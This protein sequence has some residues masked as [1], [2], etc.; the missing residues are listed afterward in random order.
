MRFPCLVWSS[1]ACASALAAAPAPAIS[2]A[3]ILARI[4]VLA[5]DE[6][7]GRAPGSAGED[8]TIAFLAAEFKRLGLQPGNPDGS[9]LQ[10]VPLVGI[11]TTVRPAFAAGGATLVPLP[12]T[13]FVARSRRTAPSLAVKDAGIIFCGYG[14]V[15]PEYQWDDFKGVD[16]RGK[17]IVVLV[18]DPPVVDPQT[19]R[20]DPRVFGGK[21]MT[22]YGRWDYKYEQA[23]ALGAAACLIVHETGPAAY[24]F[25][26]VGSRSGQEEFDLATPD[27]NAGTT[28]VQGWVSLDFAR[29]LFRAAGQ[30]YDALK[31]AANSRGFKPV[32]L[33]AQAGFEVANQVRHVTS[34]NVVA[35]LPGSDAR[36]KDEYVVYTAHWDHLGRDPR[37]KGD[38]IFNGAFDNASGASTL[39][40]I[41]GGFAAQP[42]PPKR[43]M[44]FL[45]VTGEERGLLGAKYYAEHPLYPL[46]RTLADINMDR[47][48]VF[49]PSR[50]LE[51]I[52][53][54]NSTIDDTAAAILARSQRVLVPDTLPE[55]GYFYRSDHF[56]FA[57]QGVPAFYTKFGKDLIGQPAGYGNR[58]D[59]DYT[60]ND[61]HRVS[62]EVKPTWNLAGAEAD[63]KFLLELG[64]TIANGGTWP[65]WKPGCEFKARREAMLRAARK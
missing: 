27:G 24:P 36:L 60:N 59:E 41:A 64:A 34:H 54:G 56:E 18:N 40:E 38:Q 30:D 21:A 57:K 3:S 55:K 8:K 28:A 5:S 15:A 32:P 58:L 17:T 19:G 47:I 43:T 33:A 37:L 20:L 22:Y 7:E 9:F 2:A 31:A 12:V 50:D 53:Y 23:S 11:T 63:A 52:G 45:A 46:A 61:Y 1:L 48:Q 44:I 29:K 49:G 16:V 4:K 42:I 10:S 26:I 39:V 51:V 35:K 62:D 13:E 14:V 6:F 25:A 65:E